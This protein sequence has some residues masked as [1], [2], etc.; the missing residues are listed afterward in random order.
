MESVDNHNLVILREK[1]GESSNNLPRNTDGEKNTS[2]NDQDLYKI[3]KQNLLQGSLHCKLPNPAWCICRNENSGTLIFMYG[4]EEPNPFDQKKLE[5]L[6]SKIVS[7]QNLNIHHAIFILIPGNYISVSLSLSGLQVQLRD[8]KLNVWFRQKNIQLGCVQN[9]INIEQLEHIL[10]KVDTF[11]ICRGGPPTSMYADAVVRSAI[12]DRCV[13]RH[14]DCHL[15][16]EKGRVC[17]ECLKVYRILSDAVKRKENGKRENYAQMS[18]SPRVQS[19][20][21]T[22][23]SKNRKKSR[24]IENQSKKIHTLQEDLDA[25]IKKCQSIGKDELNEKLKNKKVN[26]SQVNAS[27]FNKSNYI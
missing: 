21:A 18:S 2:S 19:A 16:L 20:I 27:R 22:L 26:Q 12:K 15:V 4:D 7:H 25:S 11:S 6:A 1:P 10:R 14:K 5:P 23:Q 3:L 24:I 17:M 8:D 9:P 13:W